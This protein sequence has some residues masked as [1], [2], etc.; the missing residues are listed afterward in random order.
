MTLFDELR[1][2][3]YGCRLRVTTAVSIL[4]WSGIILSVLGI[5]GGIIIRTATIS[6]KDIVVVI[7]TETLNLVTQN[8]GAL[9]TAH[10]RN[11]SAAT[12][13]T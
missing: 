7:S 11:D 4:G 10:S 6:I 5:I 9:S 3:H 12:T 13:F 1:M 2:D 8:C